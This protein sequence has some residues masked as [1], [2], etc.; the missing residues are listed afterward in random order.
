MINMKNETDEEDTDVCLGSWSVAAFQITRYVR[1]QVY[2]DVPL[3]TKQ[4]ALGLDDIF[5]V[6]NKKTLIKKKEAEILM[7]RLKVC[8]CKLTEKPTVTGESIRF[9][10]LQL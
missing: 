6:K 2:A 7:P 5:S 10:F 4:I 8:F 9:A 3:K 1:E